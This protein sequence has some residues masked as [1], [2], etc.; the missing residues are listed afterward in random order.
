MAIWVSD[1]KQVPV[2]K[3]TNR[4]FTAL[5]AVLLQ[6]DESASYF[7]FFAPLFATK[8]KTPERPSFFEAQSS[9]QENPCHTWSSWGS[10]FVFSNFCNVLLFVLLCKETED[11]FFLSRKNYERYPKKLFVCILF[12]C[13]GWGA[14]GC[15]M[16]WR[17]CSSCCQWGLRG[18]LNAKEKISGRFL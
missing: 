7:P 6:G 17:F 14:N 10:F 18:H 5:F 2:E 13:F 9:L 15:Q 3:I 1:I 4:A 12:S 11:Q 8:P 16:Y